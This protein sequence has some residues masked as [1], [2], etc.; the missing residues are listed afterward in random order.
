MFVKEG[1]TQLASELAVWSIR[2]EHSGEPR[3]LTATKLRTVS[4]DFSVSAAL[5]L[6]SFGLALGGS[7]GAVR[8]WQLWDGEPRCCDSLRQGPAC[9]V[10]SMARK[11][12]D[13]VLAA[14]A[15]GSVMM[16]RLSTS[17]AHDVC[18]TT[19]ILGASTI[20]LTPDQSCLLVGRPEPRGR[21]HCGGAIEVWSMTL[22]SDQLEGVVEESGP[23]A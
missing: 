4:V 15:D 17:K 19:R 14:F 11:D 7:D 8:L 21:Y 1:A 12:T 9:P 3:G 22:S 18:L 10:Q 13:I 6:D 23:N 5:D 20:T 2:E 16:W